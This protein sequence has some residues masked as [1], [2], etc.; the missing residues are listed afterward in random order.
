MTVIEEPK[1]RV[2]FHSDRDANPIFHLMESI[3]MLAGHNDVAFLKQFNSKIGQ[4]SD[5]GRVFNAAY[6]HRMREQ[7][8][9]DQLIGVIDHLTAYPES[10]QAVVQLWDA[11][12]LLSDT[13][14]RACNTQMVFAINNGKLDLTI[15]NRSNDMWYGYCGANP[16]HFSI[17]QEFVA[18]ALGVE[19]GLYYTVSNNLHLY[20]DLYN[21][22]GYLEVPPNDEVYDYYSQG[23]V[24][25]KEL[26][27]GDYNL[28]LHECEVFCN[29]PFTKRAYVN[30]FFSTVAYPMAMVSHDRKHKISDGT[31]W[32][33]KISAPDWKVAVQQ[34]IM[35]REEAKNVSK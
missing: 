25:P 28:F 10:R 13:L 2:L 17:I 32:A 30:D 35:K 22:K 4:Y 1:E 16:V 15:F 20:L 8:G 31:S 9:I 6:G 14:D 11:V 7:F 21:A 33:D 3:W 18:I 23:I 34:Y 24:Q 12:D 5:D 26:Y 29:D 27:Q 19:V